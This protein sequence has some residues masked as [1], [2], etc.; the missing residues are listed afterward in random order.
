MA[1]FSVGRRIIKLF[2][3]LHYAI[4]EHGFPSRSW[5]C[6]RHRKACVVYDENL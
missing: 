1:Y 5:L 2:F 6:A 3:M 4:V